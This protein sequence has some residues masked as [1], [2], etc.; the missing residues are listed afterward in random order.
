[1][2]QQTIQNVNAYNKKKNGEG[3]ITRKLINI[4]LEREKYQILY[5]YQRLMFNTLKIIAQNTLK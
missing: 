3:M 4:S 5:Y 1:M 2:E